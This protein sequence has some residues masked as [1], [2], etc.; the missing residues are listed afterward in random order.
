MVSLIST[1]GVDSIVIVNSP[2]SIVSVIIIIKLVAVISV[3][4]VVSLIVVVNCCDVGS[5]YSCGHMLIV[6]RSNLRIANPPIV[7]S[8]K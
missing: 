7:S 3:F 8:R 4:D 2:L 6:S 5:Q 1:A